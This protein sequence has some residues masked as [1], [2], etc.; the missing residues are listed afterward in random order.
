MNLRKLIQQ[1]LTYQ[2]S[3]GWCHLRCGGYLGGL[4]RFMGAG[5][6]IADVRTDHV[7]AFLVGSGPLTAT[8]HIKYSILRSF[9]RYAI[10]RGY[11]TA[12]PLPAEVPQPPSAFVPYI[13]SQ[14]ELR[15]L[16]QEVDTFRRPQSR[17]EPMTMRTILLLLYG[18]GLRLQEALNLNHADMNWKESLLTVRQT[19]FF[20]TRLVPF[21]PRLGCVLAEHAQTRARG[22]EAPLFTTRAHV[23]VR[24]YLVQ[25]Y[26]RILC[27]RAGVRRIDGG[28]FQPRLHDLRHTFAVHRLTSWYQ[29]GADVQKLLPQLSTYLGHVSIQATQVYLNMTPE[30][31]HEAGKRFE[32]YAGMEER[33]HE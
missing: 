15:R 4:G 10:S 11:V 25:T 18:A 29:Q 21:G 7:Q 26:F 28:R 9:Y 30:L 6:D 24:K 13:Y 2:E 14:E 27:E 12:S 8:W 1:Y 31:L 23:R 32:Q 16:F 20:K 5:V 3:L 17:L 33:R 19:K 22:I